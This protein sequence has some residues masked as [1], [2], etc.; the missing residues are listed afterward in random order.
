MIRT[1]ILLTAALGLIMSALS[2]FAAPIQ[3][4]ALPFTI[5]APGTY[6]LT[7]NLVAPLTGAGITINSPSAGKIILDLEGYTMTVGDQ[8]TARGVAIL[9]N[10][11]G[12][13]I[14]IQN[15]TFQ[16]F[17]VVIDVNPNALAQTPPYISNVHIENINFNY[18]RYNDVSFFNVN[19]SSVTDCTF[20]AGITVA[21]QDYYSQTGNRY[22][23]DSFNINNSVALSIATI[24]NETQVLEHCH[25]EVPAN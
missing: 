1:P 17:W 4:S 14:T 21:I 2:T 18:N 19:S 23:N 22:A 24:G 5:S 15:G 10:P 13:S 11:T 25:V 20:L 3:I 7:G 12:S 16:N 8:D 9:S 6:Q